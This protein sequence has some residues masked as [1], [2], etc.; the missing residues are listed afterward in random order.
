MH[1]NDEAKRKPPAPSFNK[2]M[3]NNLTTKATFLATWKEAMVNPALE[4]WNHKIIVARF[5]Q[6]PKENL[7]G[8]LPLPIRRYY[9]GKSR[10][11]KQL[12]VER[13][14]RSPHRC[15]NNHPW[16]KAAKNFKFRKVPYSSSGPE[17]VTDA[18][19]NS[20]SIIKVSWNQQSSPKCKRTR[21]S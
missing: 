17:L 6:K 8:H 1:F 14:Q 12:G 9:S 13:G 2:G 18:Q 15:A 21:E 20:L 10:T 3:L 11:P 4:S 5:D 16:S 7:E 19:R